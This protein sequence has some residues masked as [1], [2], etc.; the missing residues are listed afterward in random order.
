M[1]EPEQ[2]SYTINWR[3]YTEEGSTDQNYYHTVSEAK[4]PS[5]VPVFADAIWVDAKPRHTDIIPADFNLDTGGND[6]AM[7]RVVTNRHEDETNVGFVDGSQRAVE[8]SGLWGL[9]WHKGFE[10][11]SEKFRV[12]GS[13]IYQ[14]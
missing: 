8:L 2:A 10:T 9:K 14:K 13:D 12:D 4:Y 3:F 11:V 6:N 5:N 1:E 7:Q